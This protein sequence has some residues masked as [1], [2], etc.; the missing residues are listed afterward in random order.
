MKWVVTLVVLQLAVIILQSF[1][2]AGLENRV[3]SI[4]LQM[5]QR[6]A[7]LPSQ[8]AP[9]TA[10]TGQEPSGLDE[11]TLRRIVR[12]ELLQFR[13]V[14]AMASEPA[15][16][17]EPDI[18]PAENA[19]RLASIEEELSYHIK[20]GEISELDM[21]NLQAEIARLDPDSRTIMLRELV[22]ALNSGDLKGRL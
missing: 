10:E 3:Q 5:E 14:D 12:S 2:I 6:P 9:V 4:S 7:A 21:R 22:R 19:Y 15:E 13:N 16:A 20:Q 8:P 11:T 1:W 18:D 17:Q